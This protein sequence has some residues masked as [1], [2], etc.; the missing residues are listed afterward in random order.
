MVA[1]L[2]LPTELAQF[3]KRSPPQ[4][5]LIRGA[6]GTGKTML[7]LEI[8]R[9]FPGRQIYVSSRVRRSDLAVDFPSLDQAARA[10]TLSIVE[11]GAIGPTLR[12]AARALRSAGDLIVPDRGAPSLRSL[13]L[14]PEVLEAWSRTSASAPTI[15]VLD[16][17][18][19]LLERHLASGSGPD[20]SLPAREEIEQ[21]VLAQMAEGPVVLVAVAEHRDAPQLE[22]LVNGVVSLEREVRDG[23]L[24]RWLRIEKLRGTRVTHPSYPFSLEG[25]RFQCLEPLRANLRPDFRRADPEPSRSSTQIW[26]GSNDYAKRFGWLPLHQLTL[27]ERDPDV[28]IAAVNLLLNPIQSHVFQRGGRLFLV[29][30][31]GIHPVDLRALFQERF[32][33][34]AFAQQVRILGVPAPEE[35]EELSAVILPLPSASAAG[36]SPRTPEAARFLSEQNG[37]ENPNLGVVWIDGLKAINSL[38]PGTYDPE[39]LPGMALTYLRQSP[40]HTLW[41]GPEEEP[42]TRSLRSIAHTRLRVY[43]REGRVFV[44]GIDPR[45]PS[46]VL[47]EGDDM[48]PYHLLLVA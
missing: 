8:L 10:G 13:L 20:R 19:A 18:E 37:S 11:A 15:V 34:P 25:G 16:S 39:T 41:V 1:S 7:A 30:P 28:P 36:F 17:W 26:P 40:L 38:A 14:P 31:P 33:G 9:A 44:H 12:E 22:Y 43:A 24:E 23:R 35:S 6:P 29:P 42:M 2:N 48:A 46:L 27:I 3:L 4:A 45:T 32:P 5:L 47:S 21:I